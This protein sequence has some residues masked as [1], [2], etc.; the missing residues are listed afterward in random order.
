MKPMAEQTFL[1]L[2]GS[3]PNLDRIAEHLSDF[4]SSNGFDD[5]AAMMRQFISGRGDIYEDGYDDG[6]CAGYE[7]GDR[8]GR[9]AAIDLLRREGVHLPEN[10]AQMLGLGDAP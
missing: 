1:S 7:K 10:I 3:S 4:L 8:A 2:I 9:R 5:A 6:Q